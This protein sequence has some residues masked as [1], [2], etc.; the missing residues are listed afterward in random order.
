MK[1]QTKDCLPPVLAILILFLETSEWTLPVND[2]DI[3]DF[4]SAF[5]A[6]ESG[7]V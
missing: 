5:N 1:S 3:L 4:T 6:L 7:L 2:F